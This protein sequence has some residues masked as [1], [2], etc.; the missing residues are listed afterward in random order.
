MFSLVLFETALLIAM[1]SVI[2][3]KGLTF[4]TKLDCFLCDCSLGVR[5]EKLRRIQGPATYK[6]KREKPTFALLLNVGLGVV[7]NY[8]DD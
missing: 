6:A 7:N 5:E 1:S 2:I 8:L 4:P 3:I